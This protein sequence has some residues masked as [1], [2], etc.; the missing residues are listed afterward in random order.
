MAQLRQL[1]P[2]EAGP[3][4]F[5]AANP[6]LSQLRR[7]ILSRYPSREWASFIWCGW[8]QTPRAL[9]LT[10]AGVEAPERGDIDPDAWHVVI[11]EPYSL[12]LALAAEL[13]SLAVGVVHSHPQNYAPS[14]SALD[15]DMDLYYAG[16]FNDFAPGR[17]YISLILSENQGET[18]ISGRVCWNGK[19]AAVTNVILEGLP[20]R[21]WIAGRKPAADPPPRT[22]T[23]RLSS[24]FGVEAEARLKRSTVAVIGAGG[25]GSAA[26][27]ALA[28]AG[29]G[30][31]TVVDPDTFEDSNL[32]RVHGSVPQ[33]AK[34]GALKAEIARD[35][36]KTIAP[37][38][39][40]VAILG[41]LPQEEVVD[42]VIEADVLLSCTDTQHS[43]LAASDLAV[44]F[45]V[46]A[47][48]C[49]VMLEGSDGR[50]TG[51]IAQITRFLAADACP[52]CR[53][54]TNQQRLN[55]ELMSPEERVWREAA[56]VEAIARGE[57]PDPY[58]LHQ[59]QM[60]TV[61]YHTTAVG[62]LAAGYAIGWI[63]GRFQPPFSRLQMNLVGHLFEV[64]DQDQSPRPECRCRKARG[65][66]DQGRAH[67]LIS[68][69]THW[70]PARTL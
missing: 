40:V 46:P 25:T 54:M 35:H 2:H 32:E 9:I 29:T 15:D 67:S 59:A 10:L 3:V 12:R 60:N 8:R 41:A 16:F 19:W 31:V 49:G 64:S 24:A 63:T 69:P 56:A 53:G 37:D 38:C 57:K 33:H 36:V 27:E 23:A 39:T 13:H 44:R 28:R 42:A 22:G 43:R 30:R 17:P 70:P 45:L 62:A 1:I 7:L 21:T 61:G 26:I 52:T 50:V 66:A 5:R 65:W 6:E 47:I 34:K 51:Q 14:P 68:A 20:C 11:R 58:W 18:A 48:D 4:L 55:Q